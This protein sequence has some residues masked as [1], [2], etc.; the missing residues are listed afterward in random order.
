M[1]NFGTS[2]RRQALSNWNKTTRRYQWHG[3]TAA[4]ALTRVRHVWDTGLVQPQE[5]ENRD[6]RGDLMAVFNK[7][8]VVSRA[9]RETCLNVH[10]KSTRGKIALQ[11]TDS[12]CNK[13]NSSWI[14]TNTFPIRCG[15]LLAKSL[16]E[17]AKST[18]LSLGFNST[19]PWQA[20]PAHHAISR[21]YSWMKPEG[22]LHK[23]L[24]NSGFTLSPIQIFTNL[25][26][27]FL[28]IL[29][30]YHWKMRVKATFEMGNKFNLYIIK[31]FRKDKTHYLKI[32]QPKF[33]FVSPILDVLKLPTFLT[34]ISI[35]I[36][37][38]KIINI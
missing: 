10:S 35:C 3:I 31:I 17:A 26:V 18:S 1:S 38:S 29:F 32:S 7:P 2:S 16:R 9:G 14:L 36:C 25:R 19:R 34:P 27:D 5:E 22:S 20:N 33:F 21:M 11:A 24:C 13:K 28:F 30:H 37:G 4:L 6:L 8:M 15:Q 12:S 23:S